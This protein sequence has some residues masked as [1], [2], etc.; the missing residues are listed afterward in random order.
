MIYSSEL[1][2]NQHGNPWKLFQNVKGLKE[3]G[4]PTI[5]KRDRQGMS[6]KMKY[7]YL[8]QARLAVTGTFSE[9]LELQ[10]FPFDVQDLALVIQEDHALV[11]AK[12]APHQRRYDFVSVD[13]DNS[14]INDWYFRRPICEFVESDPSDCT[15]NNTYS[16]LIIHLK[17]ERRWYTYVTRILLFLC[18]L[19]LLVLSYISID[20]D[21]IS[22]RLAHIVTLL[23]TAVAYQFIISSYL[24]NVSY[25]TLMDYYVLF[26]FGFISAIGI[27]CAILKYW[28]FPD[29]A[30]VVMFIVF[31]VV[32][33]LTH[34]VFLILAKRALKYE[35]S[36]LLM[37]GEDMAKLENATHG[38]S[39]D[40]W[41][42]NEEQ[43]WVKPQR[44]QAGVKKG[45]RV[46][47]AH[48]RES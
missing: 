44:E 38:M 36:K 28:E 42:V 46:Y 39:L 13:R 1:A 22:D 30:D 18:I 24:P 12:L 9:R 48:G 21:D 37:Y 43:Q 35:R 8:V 14:S 17:M 31:L 45:E 11:Q 7:D 26:I 4:T 2:V 23:L 41:K 15:F 29:I 47:F 6:V 40:K 27:N 10:N 3:R 19:S 32:W 25:L 20:M 16:Q 34:V 33:V 5:D